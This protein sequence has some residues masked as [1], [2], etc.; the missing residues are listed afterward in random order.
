MKRAYTN[1]ILLDGTEQ[2][3]P[4]RGKVL[5]TENDKITAIADASVSLDGYEVI[6]LHGGYLCPGLIN[7]HVHLAGNGKPSAK[8]RDNA[9]LVRKILS[10]R[11]TRAI[12]YRLVCSYAKLEL[13]GGVTTVRTVGGI[14]DFDTRCRDDSAAGKVLAPR[15]LA[16]NEGI[17][18]PGGHMAGSVAVAAH[19]NAEA[20]AQLKKASAQK[21]D[22]VKLMIT[23][24]VLDA[25]E[26]G[27][28]GEMK[29]PPEMIKAVCDA[30]HK[31]G[32][33]VA[34][35]TES[36]AGVKAAL[37]NNAEALAQLKKASAQKVD[38]VKLMITGGVLDATEK[39]TPGEMKM[40]PEMIKAVCDAAHKL[41]Y[42]VAA[43]TE[44]P[45]GV[46]AAL[47]N[48]VDSIE[49]GAKM[50]EETVRLYKERGAFLCTTISPA[51]PYALFDTAVSGASEKDQYN[52]KIVFDGVI[53]SAK[54][55]LA[56]G[57]PVGLGN[58]VGCPYITQYDFWREL[59]YFHKYCCV[60]NRFALYTA[61]LRNA[62]LAGIGDVT[63]SIA[64][65]KS[66]DFI[67]TRENPLEDLRALQHL[68]LVVCRGRAVKKPSPKRK[69][70]VDA[71]LDPYLV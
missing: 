66:A 2:M 12:A 61:T 29:M 28:P 39:G 58:D 62:Q 18:V 7:L 17:S 50:D 59:C 69:K 40:P 23:G 15:I 47:E 4:V 55:A 32:Y 43:H 27:T 56:N 57:I 70:E 46:K 68:E 14:A 20:L 33:T 52:G 51:L 49:H 24:G 16:A 19:N 41:G 26:K 13:L 67:V 8:P 36:P 31:L 60:S 25:T 35:H 48:G 22:L 9:A 37:E 53:E 21:V 5:L 44:S 54:T 42:T 38:L 6:D 3:E 34:A 71:L 64:P 11:L 1:G 10:N 30:A 63:G 45:A 65:G